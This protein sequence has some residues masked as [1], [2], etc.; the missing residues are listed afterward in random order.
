METCRTRCGSRCGSKARDKVRSIYPKRAGVATP[1]LLFRAGVQKVTY[2]EPPTIAILGGSPVAESALSLLLESEGYN[3]RII[4]GHTT[5]EIEKS[6]EGVDVLLL[7]NG[8]SNGTRQSFLRSLRS[9]PKTALMPI[10]RLSPAFKEEL[11]PAEDEYISVAW[12]TRM[13][14][15]ARQIEAALRAAGKHY[16]GEQRELPAGERL[17]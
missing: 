2:Q 3:I 16:Y 4:E 12:P 13:E 15:L 5:E 7:Y 9:S 8:L 6:L 10:L 17:L 14:D 11:L 1:A